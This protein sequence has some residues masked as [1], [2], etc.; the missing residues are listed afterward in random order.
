MRRL[1]PLLALVAVLA[2]AA[3]AAAA[4]YDIDRVLRDDL[5]RVGPR[6]DTPI[7]L[8]ARMRLDYGKGVFGNGAATA[9]GWE[10]EI[11]ATR[12]C[13]ANV[14]FLA[15]FSGEEGGEPAFRRTVRLAKGITGYYK[16]LTCGASCSPPMIQWQQE[17][18]LYSIQAK[19]GVPGRK[20]Q[21]RAMRR[22][23]NSAI[24]SAPR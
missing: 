16:G 3:V 17:G 9:D 8:P 10:F 13:G 23:A 12:V 18:V 19:L 4:T 22:A 24:R 14:C 11:S 2:G 7:R 6:T 21:R 20:R 1:L 15:R 5:E